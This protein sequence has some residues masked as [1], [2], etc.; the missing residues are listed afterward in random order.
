MKTEP[1]HYYI[2]T[3]VLATRGQVNLV[4]KSF[5]TA[6]LDAALDAAATWRITARSANV[7]TDVES[8]EIVAICSG[9]KFKV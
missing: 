1:A 7:V 8:G 5:W 3:Q 9:R 4:G 2:V 6:D